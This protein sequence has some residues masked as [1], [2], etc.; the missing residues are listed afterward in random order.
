MSHVRPSFP[1]AVNENKETGSLTV[2]TSSCVGC[3]DGGVR[4]VFD[5]R[6]GCLSQLQLIGADG[7]DE[8]VDLLEQRMDDTDTIEG[9]EVCSTGFGTVWYGKI[10]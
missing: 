10:R 9:D 7:G 2:A 3:D 1:V 6:H 4:A 5:M 8:V